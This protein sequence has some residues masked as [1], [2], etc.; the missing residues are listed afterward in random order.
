MA[1]MGTKLR[2]KALANKIMANLP[3]Y[4]YAVALH[5]YVEIIDKYHTEPAFS[6]IEE[7]LGRQTLKAYFTAL[8]E[9]VLIGLGYITLAFPAPEG[10][11]T[12]GTEL[13]NW[14][15]VGK[16]VQKFYAEA[17]D[18]GMPDTA[19]I[20]KAAVMAEARV[21]ELTGSPLEEQIGALR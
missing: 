3:G 7:E 14:I 13:E 20:R 2:A 6:E 17:K 15:K 12:N 16:A 21:R 4:P 19:I 10:E 9:H 5:K 1:A 8:E 11:Q 18:F